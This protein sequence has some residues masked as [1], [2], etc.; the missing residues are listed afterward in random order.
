MSDL[1]ELIRD[2]A[3]RG[4]LT[5]LSLTPRRMEIE[6]GSNKFVHGW[7]ATLA[8]SSSTGNTFGFDPDPVKALKTAIEEARLRRRSPNAAPPVARNAQKAAIEAKKKQDLSDLGL[9]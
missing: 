6:E 9:D 1:E 2:V 5:H 4:E 7:S 8:P 3:Q